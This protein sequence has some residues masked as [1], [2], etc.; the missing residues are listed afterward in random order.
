MQDAGAASPFATL[1]LSPR[2]TIERIVAGRPTYLVLPLAIVG[3]IASFYAELVLMG[4]ADSLISWRLW[5][6]FVAASAIFGIVSLYVFALILKWIGR[7]L[8]GGASAQQMRAV[9]AWSLVP[10]I[11]GAAIA[12]VV[13]AAFKESGVGSRLLVLVFLLW[14]IVVF[15][16]MLARVQHF[17]VFRTI[18][19]YVLTCLFAILL[20]A[21]LRS[22]LY[23]PFSIPA[24]SMMPNLLV[25]DYAIAAKFPYGYSRFSLPFSPPLLSGRIL[26]SGPKRGDVVVFRSGQYDYVK[27]VVGLP[28]ERIQ[29]NNGM[30]LINDKPVKHEPVA[31]FVGDA[32]GS[33]S[34]KVKRWRE[35]LPNGVSYETLD[36][37]DSGFLDNTNVYTVPAGH[38]FML[39]DNRDNSSDSRV[40]SMGTIPLENLIGRMDMIFYSRAPDTHKARSERIGTMVR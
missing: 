12:L 30:L 9:V 14:T 8:R 36:C 7:L 26:A 6:F 24:S 25:G 15:L 19:A 39:G 40:S 21:T 23:Q 27:R 5:L 34:A 11:L 3:T 2:Q 18:A 1:W 16:L 28:G 17:G 31:D 4:L 29:M 10:V 32:C 35:T 37:T 33:G 20:A 38:Y 13:T 22:V